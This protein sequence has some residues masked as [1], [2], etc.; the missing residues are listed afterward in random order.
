MRMNFKLKVSLVFLM[1]IP[2]ICAEAQAQESVCKK[3]K[4]AV[5]LPVGTVLD[6]NESQNVIQPN[7]QCT[8]VAS[9]GNGSFCYVCLPKKHE[10]TAALRLS[11]K[12]RLTKPFKHVVNNSF[13]R[14]FDDSRLKNPTWEGPN[15]T[16]GRS[17]L[18]TEENSSGADST[19]T[20]HLQCTSAAAGGFVDGFGKSLGALSCDEF[21]RAL[22]KSAIKIEI[23]AVAAETVKSKA[24]FSAK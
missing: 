4:Y 2:A 10:G 15:K 18:L 7:E 21:T 6:F 24:G 12:F 5:S 1:L 23:P 17:A 22:E 8:Q 19:K 9:R 11:G 20:A 14:N 3:N 13:Y 16:D